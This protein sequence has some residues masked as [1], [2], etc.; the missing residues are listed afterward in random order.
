MV[1]RRYLR[2]LFLRTI[3]V[4]FRVCRLIS[5][6]TFL[7]DANSLG[8]MGIGYTPCSGEYCHVRADAR[9]E[10]GGHLCSK[11]TLVRE[12]LFI[13]KP[14]RDWVCPYVT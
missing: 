14:V 11:V 13:P 2:D 5:L 1:L 12:L 4:F 6:R 10:I 9:V 3:A 8:P 7:I